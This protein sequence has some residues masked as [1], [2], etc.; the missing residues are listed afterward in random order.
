MLFNV[1]LSL[2]ALLAAKMLQLILGRITILNH[3]ALFSGTVRSTT[4][5]FK[6]TK[7]IWKIQ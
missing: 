5:V 6:L 1:H 2:I 3:H 4:V 7:G